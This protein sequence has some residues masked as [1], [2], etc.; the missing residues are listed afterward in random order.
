[1]TT[2]HPWI[3]S[4]AALGLLTS[5]SLLSACGGG[6]GSDAS[7]NASDASTSN[8]GDQIELPGKA[9]EVEG[10]LDTLQD[11]VVTSVLGDQI[12][13]TLPQPL[14]P[15]V[16][17]AADAVNSLVD[18]PDALLAAL[19]SLPTGADPAVAFQSAS[20][21]VAGS[22]E[23]FAAELQSTLL[24]L[25]GGASCSTVA[26]GDGDG[27]VLPGNPLADTPLAPAGVL[28][29][30][31][32]AALG[33]AQGPNGD[34]NLTSLTN[35][36]APVLS[37]LS[38]VLG[39]LPEQVEEA[40]ILG[41]LFLTL[42]TATAD[43]A[44]TL[45]AVGE[46]DPIQTNIGV[47][48]LLNN[49]LSNVLLEVIPVRAIDERTGQNFAPR[50]EQGITTLTDTLGN[51]TGPIITPLFNEV[52]NG[53]ASPLLDPVE[54]LLDQLLGIV[55]VPTGVASGNPL[56][57]LLSPVIGDGQNTNLD[58]LTALLTFGSE[59]A[60]LGELSEAAGGRSNA[61]PL[62]QVSELPLLGALDSLLTQLA[63]ATSGIPIVGGIVGSLLDVLAS[64]LGG[65]QG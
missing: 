34:P 18:A 40:P 8:V 14:G 57:G 27:E 37:E 43:L 29:E 22:L 39:N 3:H 48:A 9:N 4:F 54:S 60:T 23:R 5:V 56:L 26:G 7:A 24:A 10:P 50:I 12:G 1:M 32:V 30:Q 33:A 28:I 51:V 65:S 38:V 19:A 45:P 36:V 61:S 44:T 15:T 25:T 20:A 47:E 35:L 31:L 17:C 58:A 13:G 59:G 6:S 63:D 41:G 52:L 62:A 16:Q 53:V 46:Y 11:Q 64:L 21:Q 42:E 49:L 2:T 55:T